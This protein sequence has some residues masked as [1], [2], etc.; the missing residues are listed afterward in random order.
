MATRIIMSG[1]ERIQNK[2]ELSG[3]ELNDF[4]TLYN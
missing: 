4:V 3:T 2:A 1:S